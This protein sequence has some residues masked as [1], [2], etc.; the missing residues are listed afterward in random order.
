MLGCIDRSLDYKELLK[1]CVCDVNNENCMLHHCD[2]CPNKSNVENYL[3]ELLSI[4]FSENDVIKY[5]QWVSTDRS[6]LEDKEEFADDFITLLSEMLC[7]LTEHPFIAK[8]QNQYLKG[9]KASLKPNECIIILDFAENFSFVVQDAAQAFHWNNTQATIH[10][11]VVYHMSNNGDLCHR[12]F[13]CISDHMTHDTV[14]VV[15]VEKLLN[16][17]VKLYLPQLQKIHYFSDRSCA[18]YKN[19]KN[20]PNLIFHVQGFWYYSRVEFLC[21]FPWEEFV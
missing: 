5:K 10:L 13:A 18:Q 12:A 14:A 6:Q 17:Y 21:N 15:F 4:K 3:K 16:D 9:L 8:N 11:F 7:K 2:D 19:Y 1:F 20:F